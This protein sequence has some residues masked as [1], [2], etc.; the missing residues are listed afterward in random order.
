MSAINS[1]NTSFAY[2]GVKLSSQKKN[3]IGANITQNIDSQTLKTYSKKYIYKI[4]K[5]LLLLISILRE[6]TSSFY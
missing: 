3:E 2:L 6:I 5:K 4:A 1:N